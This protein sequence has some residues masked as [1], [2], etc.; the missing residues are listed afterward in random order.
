MEV[1]VFPLFLLDIHSSFKLKRVEDPYDIKGIV[2]NSTANNRVVGGI[3]GS[4]LEVSEFGRKEVL[5]IC[6]RYDISFDS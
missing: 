5:L 3:G 4:Y 6:I 2:E 1:E